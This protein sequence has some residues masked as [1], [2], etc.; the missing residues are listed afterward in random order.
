MPTAFRRTDTSSP[1][2]QSPAFPPGPGASRLSKT[3][4]GVPPLRTA[5]RG[6]GGEVRSREPQREGAARTRR[7]LDRNV[8]ALQLGKETRDREAETGTAQIATARLVDAEE[9]VEDPVHVLGGD[10][11]PGVPHAHPHLRTVAP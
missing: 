1:S 4:H 11:R 8:P 6:S 9:A 10:T 7:A 3:S 2:A 5:E